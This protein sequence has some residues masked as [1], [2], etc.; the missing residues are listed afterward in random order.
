MCSTSPLRTDRASCSAIRRTAGS[1]W[2]S[3]ISWQPR[4]RAGQRG[5]VV[6][7]EEHADDLVGHLAL[8]LLVDLLEQ[9]GLAA[10]VV[11]EGALGDAGLSRH[12]LDRRGGVA[13]LAKQLSSGRDQREPCGVALGLS[14]V[15]THQ[16]VLPHPN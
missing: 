9:V 11:V 16:S 14:L 8:H 4:V 10:E 2:A 15:F 1:S 6:G 12:L 7:L 13:T 3:I 5:A